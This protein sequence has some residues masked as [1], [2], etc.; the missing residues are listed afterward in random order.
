MQGDELR[1]L[2]EVSANVGRILSY[3]E[4]DPKVKKEGLVE[5]V[6]R[7]DDQVAKLERQLEMIG[8]KITYMAAAGGAVIQ[9]FWFVLSKIFK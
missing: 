5:Q 7:L 2:R 9:I 8:F 3:L 4:S 1:E 6:N